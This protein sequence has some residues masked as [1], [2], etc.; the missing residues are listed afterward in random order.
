MVSGLELLK[1]Q[2]RF[3]GVI[4]NNIENEG[5]FFRTSDEFVKCLINVRV[6]LS[7]VFEYIP[8]DEII[9]LF[10]DLGFDYDRRLFEK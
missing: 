5:V 10:E 3:I 1:I 2:G 6:P 9:S 7:E 8:E 4:F